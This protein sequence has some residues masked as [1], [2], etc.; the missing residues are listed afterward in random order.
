MLLFILFDAAF[1]KLLSNKLGALE[2]RSNFVS[3]QTSYQQLA[4][5]KEDND[6]HTESMSR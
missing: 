1:S 5:L 6:T 2:F 3:K 4:A